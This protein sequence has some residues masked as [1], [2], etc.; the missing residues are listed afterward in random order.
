MQLDITNYTI[1]V[2]PNVLYL[3]DK[4]TAATY[5]STNPD[6]ALCKLN[7]DMLQLQ[8]TLLDQSSSIQL[9][10]AADTSIDMIINSKCTIKFTLEATNDMQQLVLT[11]AKLRHA[12]SIQDHKINQLERSNEVLL[13]SIATLHDNWSITET[14][15]FPIVNQTCTTSVNR[16][17][18]LSVQVNDYAVWLTSERIPAKAKHEY[19]MEVKCHYQTQ[20]IAYSTQN[21]LCFYLWD[22]EGHAIHHGALPCYEVCGVDNITH[23]INEFAYH[24]TC[25]IPSDAVHISAGVCINCSDYLKQVYVGKVKLMMRPY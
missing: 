18:G 13:K 22:K 25:P 9:R 14:L 17:V 16:F 19:R 3:I 6:E 15:P 5:T 10:T 24:L 12:I 21:Y 20:T 4:I 7:M 2:T 11:I 1:K 8:E 23:G